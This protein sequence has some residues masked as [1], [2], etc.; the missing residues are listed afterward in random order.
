MTDRRGRGRLTDFL[1]ST[2]GFIDRLNQ[3]VR[4]PQPHTQPSPASVPASTQRSDIPATSN[5]NRESSDRGQ[6]STTSAT[7]SG[8]ATANDDLAFKSFN[9]DDVKDPNEIKQL[10]VRQLKLLL[11]KN[12]VDFRTINEKEELQAKVMQL[13]L[14]HNQRERLQE[15]QDGVGDLDDENMCKICM[16]RE[17]NCVLLECGHYFTCVPCGKKLSECPICRQMIRRVVRTFKA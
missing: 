7:L 14:D 16:E 17:I 12:A 11:A 1:N 15:S 6:A 9:I 10:T 13:W 5:T 2:S 3:L 4:A 8:M